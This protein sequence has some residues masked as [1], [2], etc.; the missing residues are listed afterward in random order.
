MAPLADRAAPL[1]APGR[2]V[3]ASVPVVVNAAAMLTTVLDAAVSSA[4]LAEKA[5]ATAWGAS[6]V[7][8]APSVPAIYTHSNFA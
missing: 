1:D 4:P 3:G 7:I 6:L 5:A 2:A 8:V